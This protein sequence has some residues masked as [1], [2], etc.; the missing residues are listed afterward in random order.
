MNWKER[1]ERC[2]DIE[3]KFK[4]YKAETGEKMEMQEKVYENL[5]KKKL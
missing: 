3:N 5:N 4:A 2:D 1:S